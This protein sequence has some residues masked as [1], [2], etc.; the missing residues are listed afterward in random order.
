MKN[1]TATHLEIHSRYTLLGSTARIDALV[2]RAAAEGLS[3]LALTDT[4]VLYGV[5]AFEQACRAKNI[6]PIIG[7]T[8]TVAPDKHP[9]DNN[10]P[11]QVVL[12][13]Q[14]PDGYRS[15]NR[16]SS[17]V[18]GRANRET[19]AREGVGW[20]ALREHRNGLICL[21][22]GRLGW[23][24]R[25]LRAGDT[26][27][28]YHYAAKLAGIFD[29]N[30]YFS[31]EIHRATD[32]EIAQEITAMGQ[33]LGVPTVAVQPVY[34][35]DM[36][37]TPR[38]ALLAAINHNC[39]LTDLPTD[40]LPTLGDA[41]ISVH[42]LHETELRDR[43][44]QFPE[45]LAARA[46]IAA[47]CSDVLPDGS[48]IWPDLNLPDN[49]T[50]DTALQQL[51]ET[52]LHTRY[53]HECDAD[54]RRRLQRELAAI[55]RHGYAPL[56]LIVADIVRFATENHIPVGTRGSVANSLVAY[57]V[58]ITDVDPVAH[59]LLFER[60]LNPARQD[61][62]DID[63][64]FCS[65]RRDIVLEYVRQRYGAE[66]VALVSTISTMRP[67]S[68]LRE[69]AK[70]YGLDDTTVNRLV[71]QLPGRWH[72][73]PRRRKRLT[74]ADLVDNA[75]SEPERTVL[76]AA[77][78]LVGQPHHV[79][80]HPGGVVIAPHAITDVV[81]VQMAPK[82]F[83]V[84]QF[85]HR[86]IEYV[87][88]PKL[89]LLGISALT[90]L[91]DAAALVRRDI[92]P[93]FHLRQIPLDDPTTGDIIER[94]ETVGVFQC[95]S[96]GAR[97]TLR[98]L[99]ARTVRDMAV[100]NAFFKPGPA[101][102][103]MAKEFVRRYRGDVPVT[104]LHPSLEPI[105]GST[106]G[107]LLFQEQVMRVVREI[108]GLSWAQANQIRQGMSKFRRDELLQLRRAFVDGCQSEHGAEL[109]QSQAKTLWE[110]V[111]AFAG[112]GFNQGHATAYAGTAYRMTY[113]K[114]HFPAQFFAARLATY[115]GFHHPAIYI[116]EARRWGITVNGP[117]I[118]HS[119]RYFALED[120]TLW[121]GLDSI[122]D[123]RRATIGKIIAE[124]QR[125]LYTDLQNLL[126][127]VP[128]RGKEARHLIQ[129]GA[130]DGLAENR[131]TLLATYRGA[132]GGLQLA[133]PLPQ[134]P[135]VAETA[136]QRLAWELEL[137]GMPVS[138]NPLATIRIPA[139]GIKLADLPAWRGKT[140]TVPGFRLPGWTGR[141]GFY[142]GDGETFV[143]VRIDE[144]VV[145]PRLWQPVTLSGRWLQD[146]FGSGWF[147]MENSDNPT[148]IRASVE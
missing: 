147:Q 14:N 71:R 22:G 40:A 66:R 65:R 117:H 85:E 129:C 144:R 120:N 3:H 131:Q 54:I 25:L 62:P 118:N 33:K 76:R 103:G 58:G 134:T 55:N 141:T 89:D 124:R 83:W 49:Q 69:T 105:L 133:L 93:N 51:A 96:Q 63:L 7:M 114:T 37:D 111:A 145:R 77:A 87:G 57:C 100:A 10:R 18:Q 23:M 52:G 112:F 4:N 82:G 81:A 48:P 28:A 39:R 113:L 27:A 130:L 41:A 108:A 5:V 125:G 92:D 13:A 42:W 43:F 6:Q 21:S 64:D 116:A 36:A 9:G 123:L 20:E 75:T 60:F 47:R 29:T 1:A 142:F 94:G 128:L 30:T 101:T 56:F 127:R 135:A 2:S 46:D 67:K 90:V 97:A 104:Y 74:L 121:M 109:S 17:L 45:A 34:A 132:S 61:P 38:L 35:L 11:G 84:T 98:K 143:P 70:A 50:P 68:A 106:K 32:V 136:A 31:L 139:E 119:L 146:E 122:R 80:V 102:G 78:A 86:A 91:A 24:E 148:D 53:E 99:K 138:V 137:L 16:L 79:S 140:V 115:G 73:D 107:V 72:L 8:L 88:L 26:R 59:D 19:V 12:L 95:E 15:L 44:A 110:Q 126:S